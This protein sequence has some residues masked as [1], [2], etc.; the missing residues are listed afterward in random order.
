VFL[1]GITFCKCRRWVKQD[2]IEKKIF[3]IKDLNVMPDRDIKRDKAFG[4]DKENRACTDIP[5]NNSQIFTPLEKA[6]DKQNH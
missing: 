2:I 6:P 4:N 1:K 3:L 5:P